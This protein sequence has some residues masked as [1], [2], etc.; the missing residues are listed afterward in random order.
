MD[1][2]LSVLLYFQTIA[3]NTTYTTTDI[4]DVA[5]PIVTEIQ[6]VVQDPI[7]LQDI[8]IYTEPQVETIIVIDDHEQQ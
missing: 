7:L 6:A 2:L 8:L 5:S 4:V 1:T 3:P